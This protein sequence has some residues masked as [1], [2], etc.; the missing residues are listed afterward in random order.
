MEGQLPEGV[1]LSI[2]WQGVDD[3]PILFVN[4]VLG[5]VGQGAEVI[6]TFGQLAPPAVSGDTQ[7]EREA[8]LRGV[9]QIPIKPV[10]RFAL[11][12]EGLEQL[13]TVLHQTLDNHDRVQEIMTQAQRMSERGEQ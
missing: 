10:A 8:Q 9:T 5:Q 6:L 2:A 4:Q 7:A 13:V 3:L 1:N 11:T 12:R